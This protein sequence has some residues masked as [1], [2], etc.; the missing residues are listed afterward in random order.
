MN[1]ND[2]MV[3]QHGRVLPW[4]DYLYDKGKGDNL[5]DGHSSHNVPLIAGALGLLTAP[6]THRVWND[7]YNYLSKPWMTGET[8]SR[9][10]YGSWIIG[11]VLVCWAMA[12]AR[13]RAAISVPARLHL[14]ATAAWLALGAAGMGTGEYGRSFITC[15][16]ARSGASRKDENGD[17][18]D[19]DGYA[20]DIWYLEYNNLESLL[21]VLLGHQPQLI[22][23]WLDSE[24]ATDPPVRRHGLFYDR[25]RAIGEYTR[26]DCL[27][28]LTNYEKETLAKVVSGDTTRLSEVAK[29]LSAVP[30]PNVPLVAI[31][32]TGGTVS[33]ALEAIHPTSTAMLYGV[34][35]Y[36]QGVPQTWQRGMKWPV[37]KPVLWL[38]A[39]NVAKRKVGHY[40]TARY[41]ADNMYCQRDEKDWWHHVKRDWVQGENALP[42]PPGED[43]YSV[44]WD[45]T[46]AQVIYPQGTAPGPSDSWWDSLVKFLRR[47]IEKIF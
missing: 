17:R 41:D 38:A 39:D 32:R 34:G 18:F 4:E 43:V 1:A 47:L 35:Y 3:N 26:V 27:Q 31:K 22:K 36:L 11:S 45:A 5:I 6:S 9:H 20:N 12:T 40:G 2:I 42:L 15:T 10:I 28:V 8:A 21:D 44:R 24:Y 25:I 14:R 33:L 46:G 23:T 29:W 16:G 30:G 19:E 7:W 37:E 13:G